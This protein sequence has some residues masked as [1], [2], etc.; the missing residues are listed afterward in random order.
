[1]LDRKAELLRRPEIKLRF[2]WFFDNNGIQTTFFCGYFESLGYKVDLIKKDSD[3]CDIEFVGV[4]KPR[5]ELLKSKLQRI[6]AKSTP[7]ETDAGINYP[8][9]FPTRSNSSKFRV[10]LTT[11]NVRP[12]AQDDFDLVLSFDQTSFGD[13]HV[14]FPQWLMQ[15]GLFGPANLG[16]LGIET[17]LEDLVKPRKMG[18]NQMKKKFCCA[19]FANPHNVRLKAVKS[20]Q[21]SIEVFGPYVSKPIKSKFALASK[22]RFMLSFEND[23]YPGYVTE[24]LIEA[25]VSGTVPLYWGDLGNDSMINRK[26]FVNLKDFTSMADFVNHV[27]SMDAQDYREIFE[28]PFLNNLNSIKVIFDELRGKLLFPAPNLKETN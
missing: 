14:Y 27:N 18:E 21:P 10:W 11:E 5:K 1:M 12:P 9:T 2:I 15:I 26:C 20:L 6:S 22:Y 13:A 3:F 19:I 24:K 8:N 17:S 7:V 25:Y 4:F 28:Q 16:H 23:L